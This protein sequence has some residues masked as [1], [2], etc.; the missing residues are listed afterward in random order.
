[1]RLRHCETYRHSDGET[2]LTCRRNPPLMTF[3]LAPVQGVLERGMLDIESDG[4]APARWLYRRDRLNDHPQPWMVCYFLGLKGATCGSLAIAYAVVDD[5]GSLH[6]VG[7][8]L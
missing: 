3:I 4:C 2:A 7:G 6:I 1:M 8:L 5:F